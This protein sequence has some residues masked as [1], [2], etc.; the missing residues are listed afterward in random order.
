MERM[1]NAIRIG[2]VCERAHQV[3]ARRQFGGR[4]RL[5]QNL[6]VVIDY[7]DLLVHTAK[8]YG[9]IGSI[10]RILGQH[11]MHLEDRCWHQRPNC[12]MARKLLKIICSLRS[13]GWRRLA[14]ISFATSRIVD[15][16]SS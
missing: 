12:C 8:T 5:V 15:A 6:A 11:A 14:S 16:P 7:L 4:W 13:R 3:E 10:D 9:R 2:V 1:Q